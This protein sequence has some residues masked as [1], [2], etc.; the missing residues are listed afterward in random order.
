MWRELVDKSQWERQ[1]SLLRNQ[2]DQEMDFYRAQQREQRHDIFRQ[3]YN[4]HLQGLLPVNPVES[5]QLQALTNQTAEH[6]AQI[7][8]TS[9]T[10]DSIPSVSNSVST[11]RSVSVTTTVNVTVNFP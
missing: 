11:S 1:A 9:V 4:Q 10:N 2:Y 8:P 5:R 7:V 6:A 3:A